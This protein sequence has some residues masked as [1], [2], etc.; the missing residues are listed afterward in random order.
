MFSFFHNSLSVSDFSKSLVQKNRIENI[1][2]MI[3][4]TCPS[5]DKAAKQKQPLTYRLPCYVSGGCQGKQSH[6]N[7]RKGP[8]ICQ[9]GQP[10]NLV[11]G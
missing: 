8:E 2:K 10:A 3:E 1:T 7:E 9:S 6:E 5:F 11:H 4:S